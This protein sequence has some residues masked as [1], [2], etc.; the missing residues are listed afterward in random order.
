MDI[1]GALNKIA[2]RQDLTGEEMRAVMT[3]IMEGEATPS[4]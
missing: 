2:A 4:P 3:T 1:K